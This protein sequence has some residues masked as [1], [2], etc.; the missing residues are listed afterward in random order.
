MEVE[1]D[2]LVRAVWRWV[3]RSWRDGKVAV[4]LCSIAGTSAAEVERTRERGS[5]WV[6]V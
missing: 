1:V 4:A 3:A 6:W 5:L 2:G